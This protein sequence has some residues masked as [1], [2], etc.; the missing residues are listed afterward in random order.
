MVVYE[1][2]PLGGSGPLVVL[3]VVDTWGSGRHDVND[4]LLLTRIKDERSCSE[5]VKIE[6]N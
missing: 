3:L 4:I 6:I 2:D 1:A 5:G